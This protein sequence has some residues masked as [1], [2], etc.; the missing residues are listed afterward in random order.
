MFLLK[1][2]NKITASLI[3]SLVICF[4]GVTLTKAQDTLPK[5][6]NVP[7][8]EVVN[9]NPYFAAG[10][11][12]NI[13]GTING[14][15]Y[16]AG[17]SVNISGKVNGDVFAA[18]NIVRISGEVTNNVFAA[19][20]SVTID[21]KIGGKAIL[22]GNSL[23]L[24]DG[25]Q[26]ANY[27][28]AAGNNLKV[29]SMVNGNVFL[30]GSNITLDSIIRGNVAASSA[31]FSIIAPA[32][33]SGDVNYWSPNDASIEAKAVISGNIQK[34]L[35]PAWRGQ[36]IGFTQTKAAMRQF[37]ITMNIIGFLS[38]FII[39][40]LLIH[41]APK[42]MTK[43]SSNI[44]QR[45]WPSFGIGFLA[46]VATPI[47]MIIFLI[48]IIGIPIAFGLGILYSVIIYLTKIFVGFWLGRKILP[49]GNIYLGLAL[50]LLIFFVLSSI[51]IVSGLVKLTTASVGMG[52][53]IYT[54][55]RNYKEAREKEI[56]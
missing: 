47:A 36:G 3:L 23:D 39:G 55:K 16:A 22:A 5:S 50:G 18:G 35:P 34:H 4:F 46:L 11:V 42:L 10:E 26:I 19:G 9:Q 27:L 49:K 12:V 53:A 45:F 7:Q 2:I 52:T 30:A 43:V 40:T 38:A 37:G 14:D 32:N 28:I 31:S 13:S 48:T 44:S 24:A 17:N 29:S 1:K 51:P 15:V 41:F 33:I 25:S 54:I 6:V 21:K 56:I 8:D 20:N